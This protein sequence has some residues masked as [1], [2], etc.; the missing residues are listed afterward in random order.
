[1]SAWTWAGASCRGL[2]HARSGERR[3]DAFACSARGGKLIAVLCDGAGSADMGGE[4]A[5]LVARTVSRRALERRP[6]ATG[7]ITDDEIWSW[8]NEARS[9]I[10]EAAS[11]RS[12][13]ARDFASTMICVVSDGAETMVAH[14][15]DGSAVLQN[16]TDRTWYAASWPSHGEY[17]STTFFVIDDPQPRLIIS[18]YTEPISAL[19]TFTDGLERLALDFGS[20]KPHGPFFEGIVS[21]IVASPKTGRDAVLCGSLARYL[22]S[23]GVNAR[24]DDDKTLLVA[25]FR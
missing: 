23:D 13:A 4:G 19:V 8:V 11:K 16:E 6:S 12:R 14:I 18:R 24:T 22:D 3:Q 21:P 20:M 9:R 17:A 15:G 2:S 7:R 1:M 5:S 10:F 25:A